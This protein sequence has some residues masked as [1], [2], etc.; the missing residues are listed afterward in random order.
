MLATLLASMSDHDV[1]L[2]KV[3]DQ[4]IGT[5]ILAVYGVAWWQ[6]KYDRDISSSNS[7]LVPAIASMLKFA[8]VTRQTGSLTTTTH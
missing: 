3:A 5:F 8:L 7:H 1:E 6:S 4:K 2:Q